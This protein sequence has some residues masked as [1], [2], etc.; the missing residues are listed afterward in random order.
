M[1]DENFYSNKFSNFNQSYDDDDFQAETNH[2]GQPAFD[3]CYEFHH[4]Q[5]ES[6][7]DPFRSIIKSFHLIWNQQLF[8]WE[9]EDKSNE[10]IFEQEETIEYT[11]TQEYNN[12]F[13]EFNPLNPSI[14]GLQ[15]DNTPKYDESSSSDD[16]EEEGEKQ[17]E[18]YPTVDIPCFPEETSR[19]IDINL[20]FK[21]P[22]FISK[23]NIDL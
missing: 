11:R 4:H 9:G 18:Y 12:L 13:T 17:I 6:H 1:T 21:E 7:D 15:E 10:E 20:P 8:N 23:A 19:I 22:E 5:P 3:W 14:P 16:D 2:A